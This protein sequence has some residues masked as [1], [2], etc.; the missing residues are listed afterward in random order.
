M[1][2]IFGYYNFRLSRD[3]REVLEILFNG[4]KRLEYRGY[5]SAGL[6]FDA[7]PVLS[8]AALERS[9]NA[10]GAGRAVASCK[11]ANG[12]AANGSARALACWPVV[13][14]AEGRIDNLV[15]LA[16]AEVAAKVITPSPVCKLPLQE[17]FLRARKQGR[18]RC[19]SHIRRWQSSH[20]FLLCQGSLS[21]QEVGKRVLTLP[22]LM[23]YPRTSFFI[24]V[25]C[26]FREH[27]AGRVAHVVLALAGHQPGPSAG[28][29]CG[30]CAH[31]LGDTWRAVSAQQPPADV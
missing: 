30:H 1:C 2:G 29:P 8:A 20:A 14:R 24:V 13:I 28:Q 3:R 19:G 31:A 11:A 22:F 12:T 5:D 25:M 21:R 4:L 7:D 16:Y 23:G 6:S 15:K 18:Q 27:G 17:A 26:R 10:N 9:S